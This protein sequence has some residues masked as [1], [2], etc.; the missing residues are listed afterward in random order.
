MEKIQEWPRPRTKGQVKSFLGLVSYYQKFIQNYS[1]IAAPLYELTRQRN[2]HTVKWTPE[3]QAAFEKLKAMLCDGPVL[4]SPNFDKPFVL[5]TDASSTGI[6]AVLTQTVDG[7]EHPV[8]YVSRKLQKHERNYATI[9]KECLAIKW[10]IHHLKYYLWGRP[11]TLVTDHAPLKWMSTSKDTN[12]RVTRWFLALQDYNFKVEHR[13]GKEMAHA[14]ALSRMHD[15]DEVPRPSVEQRGGICGVSLGDRR[16]G[17]H[18]HR[19]GSRE[20]DRELRPRLSLGAVIDS[21]Y[22]PNQIIMGTWRS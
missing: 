13:P 19:D 17:K 18:H 1:S 12:A 2:P 21:R 5:H 20:R 22:H 6:G 3:A 8:T 15:E 11:F 14:D 16:P 4:I 9:E 10:A 7:D